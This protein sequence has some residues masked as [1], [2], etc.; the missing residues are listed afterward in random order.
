MEGMQGRE[1]KAAMLAA[2]RSHLFRQKNRLFP[3]LPKKKAHFNSMIPFSVRSK[4][5]SFS[6]S[7]TDFNRF[8]TADFRERIIV[9][10]SEQEDVVNCSWGMGGENAEE[11]AKSICLARSSQIPKRSLLI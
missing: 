5:I 7:F 8:F 9:I 6:P 1:K 3:P 2:S 4:N 10:T 11:F